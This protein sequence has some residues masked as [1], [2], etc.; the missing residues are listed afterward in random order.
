MRKC[1]KSFKL[2]KK[3]ENMSMFEAITTVNNNESQRMTIYLVL[4][5]EKELLNL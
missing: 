5:Y 3:S 2:I 1:S 4:C